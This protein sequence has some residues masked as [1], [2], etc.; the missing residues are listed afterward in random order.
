MDIFNQLLGL[1]LK[2]DQLGP[3]QMCFRG[4]VM[5]VATLL[6]IKAGHK[7]FLAKRTAF[8]FVLGLILA[9]SLSRAINGSAAFFPTI[10]LGFWLV[11]LHRFLDYL[12]F[13][14]KWVGKFIKGTD[15]QIIID[16]VLQRN[17]MKKH[18]L[19]EDDIR[20]DM[21]LNEMEYDVKNV[22]KAHLERSGEISFIKKEKN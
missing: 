3:V 1:E 16:G 9:S 14:F 8:D 2:G 5:F 19:T 12:A 7:R 18:C 6:I 13:R 4:L 21:R 20:E 15:C 17:V 10:I 22:K 11:L